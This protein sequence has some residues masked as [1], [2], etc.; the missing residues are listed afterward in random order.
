MALEMPELVR[1]LEP[2]GSENRALQPVPELP[3]SV[4][5]GMHAWSC[6][7]IATDIT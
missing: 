6:M 7:V 3:I 5:G 2:K 1:R 4:K